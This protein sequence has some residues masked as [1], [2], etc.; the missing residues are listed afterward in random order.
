MYTCHPLTHQSNL[1]EISSVR[2][3]YSGKKSSAEDA[4]GVFM[5]VKCFVFDYFS[6]CSS[7]LH[8]GG[9]F[10]DI[11][12]MHHQVFHRLCQQTSSCTYFAKNVITSI[13]K[14]LS[15]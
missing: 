10:T 1:V 6:E 4:Y 13:A 15:N 2:Q 12:Q 11:A 3:L 5:Q 9:H 8:L 14:R 7:C